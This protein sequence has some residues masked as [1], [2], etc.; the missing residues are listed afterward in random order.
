MCNKLKI[1]INTALIY[2]IIISFQNHLLQFI[3]ILSK[4]YIHQVQSVE[5]CLT[6]IK[7]IIYL[8][9]CKNPS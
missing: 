8:F 1:E 6:M 3:I 9:K 2:I 5:M 4:L 7:E